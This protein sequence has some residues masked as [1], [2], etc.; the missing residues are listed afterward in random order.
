[1][2][3]ATVELNAL[4]L[5]LLLRRRTAAERE[6]FGRQA[7]QYHLHARVRNQA[8]GELAAQRVLEAAPAQQRSA[9]EGME[10]GLKKC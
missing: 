5:L 2:F 1:M 6:Y 4:R 7:V 9:G 3:E 10:Q 8:C